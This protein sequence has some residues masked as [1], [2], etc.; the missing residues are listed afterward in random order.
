MTDV[1][2]I[3]LLLPGCVTTEAGSFNNNDKRQSLLNIVSK[4][5][6]AINGK[7]RPWFELVIELRIWLTTYQKEQSLN[8]CCNVYPMTSTSVWVSSCV[9]YSDDVFNVERILVLR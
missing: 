6:G 2:K 5:L 7:Y 3:L 4:L 1:L 8:R 9:T